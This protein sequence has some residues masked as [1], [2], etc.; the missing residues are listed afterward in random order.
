MLSAIYSPVPTISKY[1]SLSSS[2]GFIIVKGK[3]EPPAPRILLSICKA[4][5]NLGFSLPAI[6]NASA[7]GFAL[8]NSSVYISKKRLSSSVN[9]PG[10]LVVRLLYSAIMV[11]GISTASIA[12]T[13][14]SPI[15]S[16]PSI[17]PSSLPNAF[18]I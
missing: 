15:F 14:F 2:E 9:S 18:A 6:A 5:I 8:G 13:V 11:K 10:G 7:K 12:F 16:I 3:S 4:P 1:A 17:Y